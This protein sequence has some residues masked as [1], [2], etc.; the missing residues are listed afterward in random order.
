[1]TSFNT[2]RGFPISLAK[3]INHKQLK[4][5]EKCE[6]EVNSVVCNDSPRR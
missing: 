3:E 2:G 1:M 6:I 4:I 5:G